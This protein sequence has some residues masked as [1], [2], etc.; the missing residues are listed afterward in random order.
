MANFDINKART[1]NITVNEYATNSANLGDLAG[2][3]IVVDD[4]LQIATYHSLLLTSNFGLSCEVFSSPCAA[5]RYM[6]ENRDICL[7]MIADLFMYVDNCPIE[8]GLNLVNKLNFENINIPTLFVTGLTGQA[9]IN[10]LMSIGYVVNKPLAEHLVQY[11]KMPHS[12]M[13]L[14]LFFEE[15]KRSGERIAKIKG[16]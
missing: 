9:E 1:V 13:Q 12:E 16:K 15:V 4:D 11:L 6:L 5:M 14:C 3:L 8:T 2:K 10:R 7:G